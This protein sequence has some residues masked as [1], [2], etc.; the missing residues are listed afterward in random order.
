[1]TDEAVAA[2]PDLTRQIEALEEENRELR[3]SAEAFGG[4]AERL[5]EEL[6]KERAHRAMLLTSRSKP[7]PRHMAAVPGQPFL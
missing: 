5:S 6:R 2:V 3:K 4:L 7:R 1:M